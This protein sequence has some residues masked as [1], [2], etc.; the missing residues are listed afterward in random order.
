MKP[1]QNH[2]MGKHLLSN[3]STK[4]HA[5]S[6]DIGKCKQYA[7]QWSQA[8]AVLSLELHNKD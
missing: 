3:L 4:C 8:C 7:F 2:T 5:F 6:K 1:S